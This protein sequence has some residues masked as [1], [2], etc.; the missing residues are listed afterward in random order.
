MGFLCL[1]KLEAG[2]GV[3]GGHGGWRE[4]EVE[5]CGGAQLKVATVGGWVGDRTAVR[6][7]KLATSIPVSALGSAS[8]ALS[9]AFI[10][11]TYFFLDAGEALYMIGLSAP[12]TSYMRGKQWRFVELTV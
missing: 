4:N 8:R 3:G 10:L 7:P 1:A 9:L 5:D 2:L 11:P 6:G 12:S